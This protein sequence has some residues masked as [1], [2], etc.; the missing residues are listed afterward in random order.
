V[1]LGNGSLG[2]F[3]CV[4][5][6]LVPRLLTF[7]LVSSNALRLWAEAGTVGQVNPEVRE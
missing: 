3:A 2:K 4:A 1:R 7:A 5:L 6:S